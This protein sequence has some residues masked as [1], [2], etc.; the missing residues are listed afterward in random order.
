YLQVGIGLLPEDCWENYYELTLA[1]Y[2][3]SAEAEFL[4]I[5]FQQ[6]TAH[7]DVVEKRATNVLDKIKPY[8]LKIRFYIAENQQQEALDTG[9]R[10]VEMLGV[11]LSEKQPQRVEDIEGLINLPEMTDP[12]KLA[13]MEIL[14][15]IVTPAWTISPKFFKLTIFTMVNLSIQ[16]GNCSS[17]AFGYVWYGTLSCESLGDIESGYRF[18]KLAINLLDKFDARELRAKVFVLF[19]TH[20][21]HWKEHTRQTLDLHLAGLQSGLETG[22][23]E[24]ACYGAAEY[25][26]YLFLIGEILETADEKCLNKLE[27]I[28]RLKQDFHGYYLA[29]WRQG[30][31]NLRGYSES[32]TLLIGEVYDERERLPKIVADNQLTLGFVAFFVKAFLCY[33]FKDYAAAVEYGRVAYKYTS[34]VFGTYFVPTT[35]FYLSLAMLAHYSDVNSNEQEQYLKEVAEYLEKLSSWAVHAPMN[36]QHKCD[37]IEAEKARSLGQPLEAMKYYDRAIKGAREHG[38]IQEEA[39][40]YER[41]AEFYLAL[42]REEIAQTYM[43]KATYCYVRWGAT[44]KVKDLESTYPQLISGMGTTKVSSITTT[45]TTSFNTRRGSGIVLDFTTVM[46]ASQAISGAIVL[47][48]LLTKLMEIAIENAGAQKGFL[49]LERQGQLFIEASGS[50]NTQNE[51]TLLRSTAVE[52]SEQL[53][54]SLIN[55][56]ARTLEDVTLNDAASSSRFASDPYIQ[57][58]QP[59]SVLCATLLNQ[60]KL[61][62]ILYLEN[63]ITVGAFT[64]ERLE[65]LKLL[66]SQAAISLENALLYANLE[67]KVT[68]RTSELN[69][70][71]LRLEETLHELQRTQAHLIQTEKMSSLGQ[72]VAGVA[73]EINNP[74]SFIHGNIPPTRQYVQNM[75]SLINLYQQNYPNPQ[76]EIK[77]LIENIDLE[78][79]VEDLDKILNSMKTGTERIRHIV[80]SLRNFSRLDEAGMKPVD[81]HSGIDSTLLILQNRL[82][83]EGDLCEIQVVKEY[84]QLP[85][86]TCYAVQ[87]NQ[88]F[89]NI[90]SNAI[91]ALESARS[92]QKDS[93]KKPTI[94]IRTSM[95]ESDFVNISI[96]DNGIGMT[97]DVLEKMFDPFFTTKPVGQGNG[98]GLA[99]SYQIVVDRHQGQL[100]CTSAPGEG[101]KLAIAIPV[102]PR[103]QSPTA[104]RQLLH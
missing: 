8:Q 65:V 87:M 74:I 88:V 55:Y 1:L 72:L 26:Q 99:I 12:Y 19:A 71:N 14:T 37:L 79:M 4:N 23:L 3:E 44:A 61:I 78:F 52:S 13:A 25:C 75:V 89:M 49:I 85:K 16:Y 50:V 45:T 9:L 60:G 51:K 7:L 101:T 103:Q 42:E 97:Q 28:Q 36:H 86:V 5:N 92:N 48:D 20:V 102:K 2:V 95:S 29:P 47:S 62:G 90:L 69:K 24:Y 81:I 40:A 39:L 46:K 104:A 21:G 17:S 68:E 59:K 67:Q 15:Y 98:L 56:V 10:M 11:S 35:M 57:L 80:V 73:H 76:P 66:S 22:D 31:L 53:P 82:R 38:Y 33:V 93:D 64:K 83:E 91:D 27:L 96:A 100:R 54:I 6:A 84:G 58:H 77:E 18:G 43:T 34:G 30:I 70:N 32:P 94:T 63:N 41:A